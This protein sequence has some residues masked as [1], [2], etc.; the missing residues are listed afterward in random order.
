MPDDKA[1]LGDIIGGGDKK[2]LSTGNVEIDKRLAEGL[3]LESLTLIEGE[4]DTGKSVMTQQ[5]IWGAM[6]NSMCVD[7]YTSESTTK[8]F[9]SQMESMSLDISDYFAWGYVRLFAMH[10]VGFEWNEEDMQGILQR[11]INHIRN[12]PADVI[13][14]D[15]L[16]L[17]TEYTKQ[18]DLLTFLTSCKN[19][20]DLGKTILI[21]LHTYAFEE[22]TLVRIRSICDAHLNMKKALVGDKYV[23]VM[24]VVKIRG[25]RKTTGNIVSFEVH[26]GYGMKI[27]PISVARV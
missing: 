15:S 26:P 9:I 20:V 16:T 27:I 8:S 13:V 24:E 22:D 1:G 23:M 5:I 21:T 7:L 14:I 18:S 12:S 6:K 11:I 19:L 3:P 10:N 17:L 4:N 2:I 25:A